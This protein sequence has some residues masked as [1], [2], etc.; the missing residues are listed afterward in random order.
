MRKLRTF[1]ATLMAVRGFALKGQPPGITQEAGANLRKEQRRPYGP[2]VPPAAMCSGALWTE[3]GP[4]AT[5]SPAL[6]ENLWPPPSLSVLGS[7]LTYHGYSESASSSTLAWGRSEFPCPAIRTPAPHAPCVDMATG[8]VNFCGG[9]QMHAPPVTAMPMMDSSRMF[10]DKG[11]LRP[12]IGRGHFAGHTPSESYRIPTNARGGRREAP[13]FPGRDPRP[14]M[15]IPR[16]TIRTGGIKQRRSPVPG[17]R[18]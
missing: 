9:A 12:E 17:K 13:P 15:W 14:L 8:L 5:C 10:K 3:F 2:A 18:K 7:R 11:V 4:L 1:F 6:R 16:P